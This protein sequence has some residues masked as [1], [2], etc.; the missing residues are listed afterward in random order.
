MNATTAA[1]V[2]EASQLAMLNRIKSRH[3]VSAS[4]AALREDDMRGPDRSPY[5]GAG[6]RRDVSPSQAPATP[7]TPA[8]AACCSTYSRNCSSVC[9]SGVFTCCAVVW[10]PEPAHTAA[11]GSAAVRREM[12]QTGHHSMT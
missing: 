4:P 9:C 7:C 11:G 6:A 10:P 3:S 2:C 12:L 5:F 8:A 1:Q